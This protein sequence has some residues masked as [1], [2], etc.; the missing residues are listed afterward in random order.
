MSA[1]TPLNGI[2]L[3]I[4]VMSGLRLKIVVMRPLPRNLI[5]VWSG[6]PVQSLISMRGEFLEGKLQKESVTITKTKSGVAVSNAGRQWEQL[7][8]DVLTSN[9]PFSKF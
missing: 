7:S 9:D 8:C 6:P 2:S 4:T 1:R 3:S 5:R